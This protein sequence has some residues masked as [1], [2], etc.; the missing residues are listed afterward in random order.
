MADQSD[1]MRAPKKEGDGPARAP[2]DL[3]IA[4]LV[5]AHH[6]A[7]YRYAYRLTG[8]VAD[9]ED[10]AQQTFLIAQQKLTQI[11]EPRKADR[12]LFAV[13]RSCFLKNRRRRKPV[14]ASNLEM[15]IADVA[16]K[17]RDDGVDRELLDRALRD[18][19]E[20][21]RLVLVMFYFEDFSYKEIAR[22]LGVPMGTVMSRLA[23]AKSRLRQRL[24]YHHTAPRNR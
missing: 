17:S 4:R 13:L 8:S 21:Y 7:V 12:W 15:D 23:R 19:R 24:G 22:Q 20:E 9:A 18:L 2:E 11:R 16:A 6:G 10:L 14:A 3:D 5:H 1:S